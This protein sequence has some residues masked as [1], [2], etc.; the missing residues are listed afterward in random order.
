VEDA[1]ARFVVLEGEQVHERLGL[2][3][4]SSATLE[5]CAASFRSSANAPLPSPVMMGRSHLLLGA[6]GF[7]AVEAVMPGFVGPRLNAAELASGTLVACGAAMLPDLDHPQATLARCLPPVSG[8][9]SHVVNTLAGGHR[10]GTHTIWCWAFIGLLTYWALKLPSGPVIALCISSF[11]ALLMLRVLTEADGLVC[12][13]LAGVL[14][15]AAVLAAGPHYTWITD[16]V[17][18]GFGLHLL[19]DIVTTEGIPPL[20]PIGRRVAF[21]IIGPTD[22]WRERTTGALCGVAAAYLLVTTVF[23][24]AWHA[25]I[26][27][28]HPPVQA[29]VDRSAPTLLPSPASAAA[30]P[31]AHSGRGR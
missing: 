22:R 10:K 24:P 23:L 31:P 20:Y 15:G 4:T 13:V 29:S 11:A 26:A 8:F 6:A 2:A 9:V 17:V 14:G 28:T 30:L 7:L 16:A 1:E 12:L 21:P 5:Q 27:S 25:Q 18:I 3:G 19:G